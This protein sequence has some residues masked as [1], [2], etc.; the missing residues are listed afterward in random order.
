[1]TLTLWFILLKRSKLR[2]MS[3]CPYKLE[4]RLCGT[5]SEKWL[6]SSGKQLNAGSLPVKSVSGVRRRRRLRRRSPMAMLILLLIFSSACAG[7]VV[8]LRDGDIRLMEDGNYSVSPVWI[9]D[10]LHFENDMV[11]RLS[12]CNDNQ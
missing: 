7:K 2:K 4:P 12:E 11:K 1:M 5:L 6:D 8:L 9:E 10:R 3:S